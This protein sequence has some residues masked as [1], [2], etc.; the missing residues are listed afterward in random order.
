M[1]ITFD[2]F[3]ESQGREMI[4]SQGRERIAVGTVANCPSRNRNIYT[5]WNGFSPLVASSNRYLTCQ[6]TA[7]SY[8]EVHGN[9]NGAGTNLISI[10]FILNQDRLNG[11]IT[12]SDLTCSR[13]GTGYYQPGGAGD[14]PYELLNSVFQF[15]Y[16]QRFFYSRSW[17]GE[18]WTNTI[19]PNYVN[20][21]DSPHTCIQDMFGI[22]NP[23]G[24]WPPAPGEQGYYLK[25]SIATE[26]TYSGDVEYQYTAPDG[27]I[28]INREWT[29]D[30][31]F[32]NAFTASDVS[33]CLQDLIAAAPSMDTVP[34]M[35]LAT[36]TY[37][38][39]TDIG[40]AVFG[41]TGDGYNPPY[42]DSTNLDAAIAAQ[43]N[44]VATTTY[45]IIN[46]DDSC[47]L[48]STIEIRPY[49][50]NSTPPNYF[51]QEVMYYTQCRRCFLDSTA[52]IL[53]TNMDG[54]TS[55]TTFTQTNP[56]TLLSDGRQGYEISILTTQPYQIVKSVNLKV[57]ATCP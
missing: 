47:S 53:T 12:Y 57:G 22:P 31:T 27:S 48:D 7:T 9:G 29:V 4:E 39:V 45:T 8:T 50:D 51:T 33:G 15:F 6:V 16:S 52:R 34:D 56:P 42:Y 13:V 23:S 19:N 24:P 43:N 25:S 3:S 17:N 10:G 38:N 32:S 55:C 54:S 41:Y 35:Q 11:R 46:Y 26:T 44:P 28:Y 37:N 1:N 21:G 2:G 18:T 20:G 49:H 5:F 30:V 40:G 36:T 14:V